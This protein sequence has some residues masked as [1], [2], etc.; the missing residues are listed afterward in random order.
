MSE[1]RENPTLIVQLI[2]WIIRKIGV[3]A[4][5]TF[6]LLMLIFGSTA[7]TLQGLV[8]GLAGSALISVTFFALFWGWIFARS[9]IK[10][11]W[12]ALCI[13]LTGGVVMIVFAG[14]LGDRLRT[15]LLELIRFSGQA[16]QWQPGDPPPDSSLLLL[17][18]QD[19]TQNLTT[20]SA[21][22]VSWL[23]A[24]VQGAPVYRTSAVLLTWGLILW[25]LAAWGA[26]AVRRLQKPLAAAAPAG[27]LL[28]I[29]MA[30]ARSAALPLVP[31]IAG[32]LLLQAVSNYRGTQNRWQTASVDFAEDITYDVAAWSLAVVIGM[33]FSAMIVSYL[34]PQK[35]IQFT[36]DLLL[37]RG[38]ETTE[39]G[40]SLGLQIQ[41]QEPEEAGLSGTG[42]LPRGHLLRAGPDLD[43]QVVMIIQ[44]IDPQY[45]A[46]APTSQT[47]NPAYYWRSLTYDVYTGRGWMTGPTTEIELRANEAYLP[48]PWPG[49]RLI[50]QQIQA[51]NDPGNSIY[52]AGAL[53]SVNQDYLVSQRLAVESAGAGTSND[54][55]IFGITLKQDEGPASY[56]VNS[57]LPAVG[58]LQLQQAGEAYPQWIRA[59]YL[60]LPEDTPQRVL[61]LA[62]EVTQGSVTPYEKTQ[63]I[64]GYLRSIPY[65]LDVPAPPADQDVAD[66]FLFDLQKGYC[67]Y[68]ATAM[69][70][71][72]RGIG[73]PARLV[74]GYATGTYR[75]EFGQDGPGR[76]IVTEANAHSWVEVYFPGLGWIEFEPT[77]GL[78]AI[79]RPEDI[80]L[81]PE[82]ELQADLPT[83]ERTAWPGWAKGF[84]W[85]GGA[86]LL[87]ALILLVWQ[88]IDSLRISRLDPLTTLSILYRRIYQ[89]GKGLGVHPQPG[90]TPLEIAANIGGQI[91]LLQA[92]KRTRG[93]LTAASSEAKSLIAL[94]SQAMYSRQQPDPATRRQAVHI[95]RRLFYKLGWVQLLHLLQ[96]TAN[97][98]QA[99]FRR[100]TGG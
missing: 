87:L 57:Q 96:D 44:V 38:P 45:T 51:V 59:R 63:A 80:P 95:W 8:R 58:R 69:V 7:A 61:D 31:F 84:A 30:Y 35:M 33:T 54:T 74:M 75:E 23:G 65:T 15:L 68:Y 27:V 6:C 56:V 39:L 14:N 67:D 53:V 48:N 34:S 17:L 94:Y 22:F 1:E 86:V 98:I 10:G 85:G 28:A 71:M 29:S 40:E 47:E 72:A 89:R 36:Q 62:A 13:A 52:Y 78:P 70:V 88:Q 46:G 97:R 9:R 42:E 92:E 79:E 4:L 2:A 21:Q 43:Q 16:I 18:L 64:E 76:Y 5:L 55:D 12:A 41:P 93:L 19:I 25:G 91:D 66:Y 90:D 37:E 11:R 3:G 83:A 100:R 99:N 60:Q 73:L 82:L 50:H 26:W 49:H 20:L 81:D 77:G 32:T 24:Q